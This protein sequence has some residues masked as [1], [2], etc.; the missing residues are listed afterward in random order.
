MNFYLP[1][2][3]YS[4]LIKKS[5][6]SGENLETHF[7]P[8][9]AI[10]SELSKNKDAIALVPL[11]NLLKNN[12]LFVSSKFGISFEGNL[13]NSYFYFNNEAAINKLIVA[14]DVSSTEVLLSKIIFKEEYRLDINVEISQSI[15]NYNFNSLLIGDEN[16]VSGKI[17]KGI[18]LADKLID[19][20]EFQHPFV[21]YVLVSFKKKNLKYINK[22]A[23]T[24]QNKI[25]ELVENDEVIDSFDETKNFIKENI[26]S[27][28]VNFEDQDRE[29]LTEILKL[30][31]YYSIVND[32]TD[33]KFV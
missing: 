27:L 28:I 2:N 5:L 20:M 22:N 25:Y 18:S 9:A 10:L 17:I 29:A 30:P 7:L 6:P 1:N 23:E 3:F 11:F 26:S 4:K 33:I 32:M 16:F 21:N 8:S 15:K 31:Y 24:I 19:L 13:S 14:G 12:N